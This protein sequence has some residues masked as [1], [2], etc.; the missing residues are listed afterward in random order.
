MENYEVTNVSETSEIKKAYEEAVAQNSKYYRAVSKSG[1]I[2]GWNTEAI[3]P[4]TGMKGYYIKAVAGQEWFEND[5]YVE[6]IVEKTNEEI[7]DEA[8]EAL[9]ETV[10][11]TKETVVEPENAPTNEETEKVEEV[12]NKVDMEETTATNEQNSVV[13][14][15][16]YKALYETM[17]AEKSEVEARLI[18]TEK[19]FA[20]YKAIVEAFK[21]L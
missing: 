19:A 5:K 11:E 2:Y 6:P 9:N 18:E 4:K 3:N 1:A 8:V 15:I 7:I 16:D 20:E 14:E 12:I 10:E 13:E 21:A 17:V